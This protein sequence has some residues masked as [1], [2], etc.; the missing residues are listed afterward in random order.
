MLF[1][2]PPRRKELR[3]SSTRAATSVGCAVTDSMPV[4]I[5]VR[6]RR[7]LIRLRMRSAC[8]STIWKN[9][10]TSAAP[11][12]EEA[13][14]TVAAEPLMV[15]SGVRSSWLTAPRNSARSRSSS[16]SGVMSCRVATT[17]MISPS[18][19]RIGV[20]LTTVVTSRPSA[21]WMTIASARTV[22]PLLSALDMGRSAI[23]IS[24]PSMRRDGDQPQQFLEA[25]A[26]P[27]QADDPPR[28]LVERDDVPHLCVEDQDSDRGRVDQR[29]EV[30]SRPVLV[31]VTAGVRNRQR[32]L[33]GEHDDGLLVFAGELIP[34][35][36]PAEIDGADLFAAIADRCSQER[37]GHWIVPGDAGEPGGGGEIAQSP[38]LMNLAEEPGEPPPL[39]RLPQVL[40]GFRGNARHHRIAR[41]L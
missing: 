2:A 5:L 11:S 21:R 6:S 13:P 1:L 8:S 17:E 41:P 32:R 31:A 36:L 28:L 9:W 35:A 12:G 39:G 38:W 27:A 19:E 24:R 37:P 26:L 30:G 16:S 15:V 22:S 3:A 25:P 18:A 34:V 14:S 29:L 20:A 4:S 7:S 33:G 23:V 40:Q 10:R